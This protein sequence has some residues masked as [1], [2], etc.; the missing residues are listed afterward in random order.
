MSAPLFGTEQDPTLRTMLTGEAEPQI[1]W[2]NRAAVT[3][4]EPDPAS[5][6]IKTVDI[7]VL[8]T[9][10]ESIVIPFTSDGKIVLVRR[11]TPA[12]GEGAS[13]IT[14]VSK[15]RPNPDEAMPATIATRAI[16]EKL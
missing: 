1:Q 7:E 5:G 10:N 4:Q 11:A 2:F 14:V 9:P 16:Q 15:A 13:S 12:M 6:D 8:Q 3:I